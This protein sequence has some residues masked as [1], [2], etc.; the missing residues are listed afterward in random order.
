M[1]WA[2]ASPQKSVL[3]LMEATPPWDWPDL[4]CS[5]ESSINRISRQ[6]L[7]DVAQK[8]HGLILE[9]TVTGPEGC[10]QTV[11]FHECFFHGVLTNPTG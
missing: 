2:Q 1:T 7:I 6:G 8:T 9:K 11:A 5:S 3:I 10:L 4:W